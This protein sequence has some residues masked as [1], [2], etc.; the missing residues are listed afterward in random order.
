MAKGVKGSGPTEDIP[1]RTSFVIRPSIT[2]KLKY[3]ALMDQTTQ[4]EI[5]GKLLT[6]YIE[7]WEK[8]NG[9][10]PVK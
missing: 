3:I 9:A 10:I 8:K 5:I 1:A 6:D 2:N 7:K 4:T